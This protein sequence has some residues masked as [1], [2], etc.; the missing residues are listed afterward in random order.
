[1][2]RPMYN[3]LYLSSILCCNSPNKHIIIIIVIIIMLNVSAL[4][5]DDTMKPATPL[6]NGAI[7]GGHPVE[8]LAWRG[9]KN[10]AAVWSADRRADS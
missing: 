8:G 6:T 3:Y 5:L 10:V 9:Q 1:M 4:L 2:C 7:L